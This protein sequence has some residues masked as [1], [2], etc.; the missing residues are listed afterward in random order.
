MVRKKDAIASVTKSGGSVAETC[1]RIETYFD[2]LRGAGFDLS[3][4]VLPPQFADAIAEIEEKLS[5]RLPMDVKTFLLRGLRAASG[6]ITEGNR[7]AHIGFD[8]IDAK[9]IVK[10]TMMLRDVAAKTIDDEDDPHADVVR[11][12]VV[13]TWSEPQI[14]VADAVYHFS[15]RNP[16]LRVSGSFSEFLVAFLAAG[17]FGSHDFDLLWRNVNAYVPPGIPLAK[18]PWIKAYKRAFPGLSKG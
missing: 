3:N 7:F 14:V 9:R 6:S 2:A 13:L 16:V 12:G 17:C 10:S 4:Q 8:W 15:F 11:S 5:T 18:N 1:A